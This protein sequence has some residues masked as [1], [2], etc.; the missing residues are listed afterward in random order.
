VAA[1]VDR[2]KTIQDFSS[3]L[4]RAGGNDVWVEPLTEQ[5]RRASRTA[6]EPFEVWVASA[7]YERVIQSAKAE[8]RRKRLALR[9]DSLPGALRSGRIELGSR[10]APLFA[11]QVR[12]IP[13]IMRVAIVVDDLGQ[14]LAAAQKLTGIHSAITFSIMPHLPYSRE[15]AD[16]AHR[17]GQEVMLHL[18]MQPILDSAPDISP[19]ELRVGMRSSEVREIV[20]SDL[21]SVPFVAGVNNHM[22]SRATTDTR[23]MKEVM[24]ALAARHLYFVDSRTT[25]RSVALSAARQSDVSSFYR[26]VFLDDQRSV[27]Y[28]LGQLHILCRIAEKRGSALAIG[29]PYSTTIEAL[30]QFLPRLGRQ[31]IQLVP[32]S[33]LVH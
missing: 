13:R 3:A 16:A 24:K 9:V 15:T 21:K 27:P 18:P 32:A 33:R 8:A 29:H 22:G 30:A 12:E 10:R 5:H 7:A 11:F 1:P 31:G 20:N 6:G 25:R 28:T 17:A 26:S 23:L 4:D 19:D 2:L 14:N